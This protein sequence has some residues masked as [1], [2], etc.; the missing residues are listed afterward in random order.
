MVTVSPAGDK[1]TTGSTSLDCI[2]PPVTCDNGVAGTTGTAADNGKTAGN[3]EPI[4]TGAAGDKTTTG[5]TSLD[6][7]PG[8]K[9]DSAVDGIGKSLSPGERTPSHKVT[10]TFSAQ[11]SA[12]TQSLATGSSQVD[13]FECSFDGGTFSPCSSPQAL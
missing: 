5:S 9:I 10:F 8:I 7:I 13:Q 6:C 4:G 2:P 11:R 3:V 12:G 1:T